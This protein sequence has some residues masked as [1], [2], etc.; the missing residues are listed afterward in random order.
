M[1]SSADASRRA[2]LRSV[3]GLLVLVIIFWGLNWPFLKT[4]LG[5]IGPL[6]LAAV[7][8]ILGAAAL[9][10][11]LLARRT[12]KMPTRRDLPIVFSVGILQM[13]VFIACINIGLQFVEAGRSSILA[14]TTSLWVLPG[15]AIFL[16]ERLGRTH[17]LGFLLGISGVAVLFNPLS[18]DWSDRSV[19]IGNGLLLL[20]AFAWAA[21]IVHIRG[22]EWE[23]SPLQLAPWQ[24]LLGFACIAPFA[25]IFERDIPIDASPTLIA[26]I[27]YNGVIATAFGVWAVVVVNRALPAATTSI[28]LL[29]VPVSG[30]IFSFL[31]LGEPLSASKLVGLALIL[32]GVG[33]VSTT[34][35][36]TGREMGGQSAIVSG[37]D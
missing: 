14:Y 36:R 28:V 35:S 4:A 22:H 17:L 16:G 6:T 1:T 9:F 19:V 26:I 21:Q 25:L 29:G 15:A 32:V 12:I 7:R 37:I 11:F 13:G 24:M 3:A 10:V 5:S 23:S 30:L 34:M 31:L 27:I 33:V 8:L 20:A 18:F 2:D